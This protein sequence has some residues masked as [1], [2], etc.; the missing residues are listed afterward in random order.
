MAA[1]L[2][3]GAFLSAAL[4]VAFQRLASSDVTH[5]FRPRNL[6]DSVLKKLHITLISVNQVLDGAEAR[7][8]TN[9]NVNKWLH[10]L[11]HAVYVADDLLDEIATEATRLKIK[12]ESQSA[13]SNVRGIFTSFVNQFEKH[14]EERIQKVLDELEFLAK[15]K[16]ALGLKKGSGSDSEAGVGVKLSARLPT[17]SLVVDPLTQLVYN[18][19]RIEDQ[20]QLKAWV[21]ISEEFDVVRITKTILSAFECFVTG[22]EDL[23]Q[24][25]LK[26][27]EKLVGRKFLLVLDDIW[28]ERQSDWEALQVPFFY[29]TSGSKIIV[30]TRSEK[31]ALVVC[32]SRVYRLA[33]LNEE[34]G[35]KLFAEY[36]FRNKDDSMRTDLESIGKMIVQKCKGL[37]LAIKTLG[38][39]LHTKSSEKQ[40]N[41]ILNCEIWQLSD[42]ESD[43]MPALRLSYHYLPSYL[44]RCFAFCSIFLKDYPIEKDSLILMWMAEDLLHCHQGNKNVEEMGIQILAELE[45]R[46][47]LQKST[48]HNAYIMHDLVNDFAKSTSGQFCLRIEDGNVRNIHKNVRYCSYSASR[49]SSEILLE[50]FHECKQLRCFVSLKRVPFSIKE[51]KDEG[52]ILSKFKHLRILSLRSIKTITKLSVGMNNSKHL[53]YLDLS[54][55]RFD[56]VPDSICKM[57]NLQTLKLCGCIQLVE[58][59]LEL[60]KL[61]N[62][63]YLDLSKTMIS[64]LPDS[65]CKLPNLQT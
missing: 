28:N 15:Q 7:Q 53:R 64:K 49:D 36:A 31:V 29:G 20:F 61:V 56:Q 48:T 6:K 65:L 63:H 40:W 3:G 4:Q 34:D 14:I 37:P 58:L 9:P 27:K 44:K 42:D 46:S 13:T 39:L 54:D 57:Y 18:N 30:K 16:D 51:G 38:G 59:P 17:A 8:Y 19:V 55:T 47:F 22:Y 26:L 25:Q 52:K 45:S 62:L 12:T 11:R 33:L 1:E 41:E 24:L 21:C 35:W 10:E 60:D 32:S 50:P 43:I 2:V 23:N 5:Y